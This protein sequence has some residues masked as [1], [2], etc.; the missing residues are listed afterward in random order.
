MIYYKNGKI[1][2]RIGNIY[3]QYRAEFNK[4]QSVKS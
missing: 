2:N 4:K 3:D 1:Q